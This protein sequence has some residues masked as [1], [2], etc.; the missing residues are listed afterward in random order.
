MNLIITNIAV[1]DTECGTH[2]FYVSVQ[3]NLG[4]VTWCLNHESEFHDDGSTDCTINEEC[5][6]YDEALDKTAE[7]AQKALGKYL[8]S[9]SNAKNGKVSVN[10]YADSCIELNENEFYI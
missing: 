6:H 3:T 8:A 1:T 7:A 5:Q 9:S 4:D 2:P 10:T